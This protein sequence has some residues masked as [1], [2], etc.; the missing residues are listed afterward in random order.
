MYLLN[1]S[2]LRGFLFVRVFIYYM[3]F[4]ITETQKQSIET[5][6]QDLI[7]SEFESIRMESEDWDMD[8]MSELKQ[9]DSVD[10]IKV[11]NV[12]T[13][14]GLKVYVDIYISYPCYD[15]DELLNEIESR[16]SMS[17]FPNIK[18]IENEIKD[19][20]TSGIGIDW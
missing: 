20:R 15:F 8:M 2:I 6:I 12:D 3:R 9:V 5:A 4:L 16:I 14:E 19:E 1:P 13:L 18:I 11:S 7:D 10:K 17:Y